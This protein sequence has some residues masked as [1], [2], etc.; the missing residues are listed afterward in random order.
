[1]WQWLRL[2]NPARQ[3]KVRTARVTRGACGVEPPGP[4]SEERHELNTPDFDFEAQNVL[5]MPQ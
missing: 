5:E 4:S 2:I 1:M 3:T